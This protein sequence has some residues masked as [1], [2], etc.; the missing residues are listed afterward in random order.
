MLNDMARVHGKK[1]AATLK[2]MPYHVLTQIASKLNTPN[3]ARFV[4]VNKKMTMGNNGK[5]E[6]PSTVLAARKNN[7]NAARTRKFQAY[8]DFFKPW[9]TRVHKAF[10]EIHEYMVRRP[11]ES[12]AHYENYALS[13]YQTHLHIPES[14][15]MD[16]GVVPLVER[17]SGRITCR[18]V[19]GK[20]A[21]TPFTNT[22]LI[23]EASFEPGR[24]MIYWNDTIRFENSHFQPIVSISGTADRPNTPELSGTLESRNL[25]IIHPDGT[26][27]GLK[28]ALHTDII[29]HTHYVLRYSLLGETW[30]R[31]A[32]D[33]AYARVPSVE[34][35]PMQ[36]LHYVI[37]HLFGIQEANAYKQLMHI[38]VMKAQLDAAEIIQRN[39]V[40]TIF[41]N[42]H[43]R[44]ML[45][46]RRPQIL[47]NA[48][49]NTLLAHNPHTAT[50]LLLSY[51]R[52]KNAREGSGNAFRQR[53]FNKIL[54]TQ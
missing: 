21:R 35:Y 54:G 29:D 2:N 51:R 4:T 43:I 37:R 32:Q 18:C 6:S 52:T 10:D 48:D 27:V 44:P 14:R 8:V 41:R 13:K 16:G 3:L 33:N 20:V 30:W 53:L 11:E 15:T 9:V 47:T 23:L 50:K 31:H 26:R 22:T 5:G 40:H 28:V 36:V 45:Q 12:L 17:H 38:L 24:G 46:N 49:V 42:T 25:A 39:M 19:V 34:A 1:Q 7:A